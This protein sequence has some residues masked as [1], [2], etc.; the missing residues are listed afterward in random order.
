MHSREWERRVPKKKKTDEL[1]KTKTPIDD[2]VQHNDIARRA[3]LAAL[4]DEKILKM[5]ISMTP[6]LLLIHPPAMRNFT[7]IYSY[8]RAEY[9]PCYEFY[10]DI[11]Y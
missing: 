9:N 4:G 2:E 8:S 1:V 6:L 11:K 7:S 10:R 3:T 5:Q